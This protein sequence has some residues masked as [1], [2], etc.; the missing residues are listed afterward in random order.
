MKKIKK[1][2]FNPKSLIDGIWPQSK[3][4]IARYVDKNRTKVRTNSH[5]VPYID[6]TLTWTVVDTVVDIYVPFKKKTV[7]DNLIYVIT[8]YTITKPV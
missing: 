1:K 3:T 2:K 7:T 4:A 5:Y 8:G 6:Y